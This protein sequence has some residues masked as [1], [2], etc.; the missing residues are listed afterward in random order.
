MLPGEPEGR[1]Y[2]RRLEE[3]IP[4]DSATWRLLAEAEGLGWIYR[5]SLT[6]FS[7]TLSLSVR[8]ARAVVV[9]ARR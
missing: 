6:S 3:G 5:D 1:V 9:M 8:Y 4:I 7:R 2:R